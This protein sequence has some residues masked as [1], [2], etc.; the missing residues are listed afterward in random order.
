MSEKFVKYRS[1][2]DK[3]L[4]TELYQKLSEAGFSVA[5]EDT[6]GYFDASF[7]NNE[8]L[9]IY[10]VKLNPGDFKKADEFLLNAVSESK[11]EPIADYYLFSFSNDELIGV[12]KKPDEWNEFDLYW[13][14]KILDTRGLAIKQEELEQAKT[15]R[16]T[17]LKKPWVLDKLWLFCAFALW[18]AA[19]WF[20]HIYIDVAVIFIGGYISFSKKTMPDGQKVKAFSATDRL[21]GKIVLAAG[22]ALA[23]YILLQYYGF[24][25]LM[26]PL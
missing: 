21:L 17:E 26:R 19:L 14:K 8:F 24:I 16:L 1:F 2:N 9:N 5:W 10:Y 4:A 6:V 22:I 23:L 11:Q 20:I 7:S 3:E 13:A 15:E 12:L 25:E 18:L